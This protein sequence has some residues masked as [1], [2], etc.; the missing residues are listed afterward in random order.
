MAFETVLLDRHE[1]ILTITLNRPKV[2]NAINFQVITEM[3]S[4]L[5][6]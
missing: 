3:E 2:L 6:D 5:D 4:A 1:G